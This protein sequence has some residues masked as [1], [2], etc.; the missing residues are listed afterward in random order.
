MN[1]LSRRALIKW[2]ADKY[3]HPIVVRGARQV[4]KS[5]LLERF[6]KEN[7]K[8]AVIINFEYDFEFYED[9]ETL[10]PVHIVNQIYLKR[11][12]EIKTGESLIFLDEVQLFP[13][14]IQAL[15]Y[16][17]E[18]MPGLH[19][20]AAGSLVDFALKQEP[21]SMP[22]GRV[23]YFY[24][25]PLSFREFLEAQGLV[26]Y[27][28]FIDDLDFTK[29][30]NVLKKALKVKPGI[31]SSG[32]AVHEKLLAEVQKYLLLGGMPA[33]I[34]EYLNNDKQFS[35]AFREQRQ[36]LNTYIDDFRKYGKNSEFYYL[37]KSFERAPHLISKKFKYSQLDPESKSTHLKQALEHLIDAHLFT[38]VRAT[39]GIVTPLELNASD[40]DFK[41]IGL[42]CGLVQNLL[43]ANNESLYVSDFSS[44]IITEQFVGQELRVYG[45]PYDLNRLYYWF[46]DA[47]NASA[48]IDYLIEIGK[49]IIPVE[50]KASHRG[51]LKSLRYF[52]DKYKAPLGIRISANPL[53]F[54]EGI[55]SVPFYAVPEIN[56]LVEMLFL[57]NEYFWK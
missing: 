8:T 36:I 12:I 40:S 50:V 35:L 54:E 21:V 16:F 2:Q 37:R 20:I 38:K 43:S 19:V 47:K 5:F 42:D 23:H 13:K 49:H 57:E 17:Y 52:M 28:K 45:D 53:S 7:F 34:R 3:P 9:F 44:E 14:A 22:V 48:E 10:D 1:R 11:N 39:S 55:L 56:R 32:N 29:S 41:I 6:A 51:R 30:R 31:T 18:K 26:G 24:M 25:H 46:N 27:L 33:V 15:R 4:G